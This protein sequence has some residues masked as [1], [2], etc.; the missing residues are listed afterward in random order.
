MDQLLKKGLY[1]HMIVKDIAE[2]NRRFA[3]NMNILES[4]PAFDRKFDQ[5]FHQGSHAPATSC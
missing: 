3:N 4:F 5:F 2:F 1:F